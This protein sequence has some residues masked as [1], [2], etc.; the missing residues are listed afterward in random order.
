MPNNLVTPA[1]SDATIAALDALD[2]VEL[3]RLDFGVVGMD[4]SG[5]TV[6]YNRWESEMAG[7]AR[8][9]VL[10]QHFFLTIG[11]CMNN[12]MVAQRFADEPEL[13]V[14]LDYVLTF[15]MLPTPVKMRL[16]QHPEAQ[17]HYM[18]IQ[19]PLIQR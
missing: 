9:T 14:T 10:G 1:F 15:R 12:F 7:L 2:A 6:R 18:L 16:L 19:H 4:S 11:I 5:R 17:F 8:E 3:D 13:N